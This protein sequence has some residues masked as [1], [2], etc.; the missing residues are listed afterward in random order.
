M[1]IFE[2]LTRRRKSSYLSGRVAYEK[3]LFDFKRHQNVPKNIQPSGLVVENLS[4]CLGIC[5]KAKFVAHTDSNG[6]EVTVYVGRSFPTIP[7]I[8]SIHGL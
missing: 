8:I 2:S 6:Q 3:S 4:E 1:V 5:R 7:S